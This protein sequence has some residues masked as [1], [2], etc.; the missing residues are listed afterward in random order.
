MDR[1]FDL[2]KMNTGERSTTFLYLSY[3]VI[4]TDPKQYGQKYMGCI[5]ASFASFELHIAPSHV[6]GCCAHDMLPIFYKQ[7]FNGACV[8]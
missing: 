7:D 6:N 4:S 3:P 1:E 5:V 2:N 8:L